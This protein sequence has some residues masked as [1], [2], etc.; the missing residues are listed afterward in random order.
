ML[1]QVIQT[2]IIEEVMNPSVI[3]LHPKEV[4]N[5]AKEIFDSNDFHHIPVVNDN[6]EVVGMLSPLDYNRVLS[7][8]LLFNEKKQESLNQRNLQSIQLEDMMSKN[9]ISIKKS[10]GLLKAATIF[11]EN[12]IHALP[13]VDEE[14]KVVGI[15]TTYDLLVFAYN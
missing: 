9:V 2:T 6:K 4:M 8:F 11:R 5:K 10:D 7:C 15:V 13:V 14:N 12:Q 1:S 3:S